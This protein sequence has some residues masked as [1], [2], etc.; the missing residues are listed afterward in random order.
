[1]VVALMITPAAT[2]YLLTRRVSDMIIVSIILAVLAAVFGYAAASY[3]DVSIAG[4]IASM[5]GVFF[6]VALFLD[7]K[8]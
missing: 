1:M 4:S 6:I 2:A 8:K 5:T 7:I 3:V